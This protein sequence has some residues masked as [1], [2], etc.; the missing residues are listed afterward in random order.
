MS[1]AILAAIIAAT[2]TVCASFLQLR[3]ALARDAD[4]RARG[5]VISRRRS[6]LPLILVGIMLLASAIGGFALSQWLGGSQRSAQADLQRELR[7]RVAE[8]G[9]AVAALQQLAARSAAPAAGVP[10]GTGAAPTPAAAAAAAGTEP[11][12]AAASSGVA[13]PSGAAAIPASTNPAE[14]PILA[15]APA[16]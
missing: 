11:A 5:Q 6:R 16:P 4:A 13:P 10:A 15:Q 3:A 1:D 2:A 9:T 12:P 14:P 7:D 8:L